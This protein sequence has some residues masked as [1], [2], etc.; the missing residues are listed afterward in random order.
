MRE[1]WKDIDGFPG[2][3]VSNTGYVRSF[4]K[5]GHKPHGYGAEWY[6]SNTPSIM[7]MSDDG[8]GYLKVMLYCRLDGHRYCKKVHR[9]VAEAFIPKIDD[10][11]TVDHIQSGRYGKLD[12][13]VDNLRWLSRRE[14]IQK[15]YRDGMCDDRIRGSLKPVVVMDTRTDDEVYY[16]SIQDAAKAMGVH[17]TTISH[18]LKTEEGRV[19]HYIVELAGR[20]DRL[21]HGSENFW[22]D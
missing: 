6:L 7:R 2:Y 19:R 17:Y 18:A 5:R 1:I 14:N 20:E 8:N 12:N 13:S 11:D 3:Q 9:L 22:Y 15:A 21:L 16:E 10:A 4:W